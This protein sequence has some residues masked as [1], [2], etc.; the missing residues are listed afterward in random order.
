MYTCIHDEFCRRPEGKSNTRR[1]RYF[2]NMD[3]PVQI[4]EC[5]TDDW[6]V[7]R[8]LDTRCGLDRAGRLEKKTTLQAP[9]N[10]ERDVFSSSTCFVIVAITSNDLVGDLDSAKWF[11]SRCGWIFRRFTVAWSPPS[12]REEE[13]EGGCREALKEERRDNAAFE[14]GRLEIF[15]LTRFLPARFN[16][17]GLFRCI[18]ARNSP[19]RGTRSARKRG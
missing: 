19:L 10:R 7:T 3:D 14:D 12:R 16:I 4:T 15:R 6:R 13:R 11:A 17:A 1:T 5:T 8:D 18:N 9:P 2:V